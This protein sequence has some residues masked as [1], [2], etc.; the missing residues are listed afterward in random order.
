MREKE[1]PMPFVNTNSLPVVE[2]LPGGR[3]AIFTRRT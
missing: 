3:D 1:F 2:R